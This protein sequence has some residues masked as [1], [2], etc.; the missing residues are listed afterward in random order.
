MSNEY[1]ESSSFERGTS[2]ELPGPLVLSA[3]TLNGDEVY[4]AKGEKL[5]SVKEIMLDV[6]NGKVCYAVI[7]FGGF[8]GMGEKL[9]AVP[10]S[11][12]V[13]D[14]EEQRFMFDVDPERLKSAPGF[15]KDNWPNMAD[16]TWAKT[17]HTYYGI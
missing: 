6:R 13:V 17:I 16:P 10:W 7:S 5:G 4:N 1:P 2:T 12:M 11:S 3:S 8:L 15:D 9:F 14:T